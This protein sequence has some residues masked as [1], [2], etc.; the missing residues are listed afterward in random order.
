M[1]PERWRDDF[2]IWLHTFAHVQFETFHLLEV[3]RQYVFSKILHKSHVH[4]RVDEVG[5]A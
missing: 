4:S 5:H 2:G 3:E 1:S